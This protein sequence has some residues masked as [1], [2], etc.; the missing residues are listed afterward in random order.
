MASVAEVATV[1]PAEEQDTG[2][3]FYSLRAK[4]VCGAHE[5]APRAAALLACAPAAGVFAVATAS[6]VSVA[7]CCDLAA[8]GVDGA[9]LASLAGA[10][11]VEHAAAS[12]VTL[13]ADGTLLCVVTGREA[14]FYGVVALLGAAGAAGAP[15]PP[16]REILTLGVEAGDIV[17]AVFS[18]VAASRELLL[19]TASGQALM[20]SG[21]DGSEGVQTRA[22]R[23]GVGAAS[24]APGGD[25]VALGVGGQV[26]SVAVS[27]AGTGWAARLCDRAMEE[28]MAGLDGALRVEA[29]AW[30]TAGTVLATVTAVEGDGTAALVALRVEGNDVYAC[31]VEGGVGLLEDDLLSAEP[32]GALTHCAAVSAWGVAVV[33]DR[34]AYDEHLSLV[35]CGWG[36][37]EGRPSPCLLRIGEDR[38]LAR[39]EM[40]DGADDFVTGLAMDLTRVGEPIDDPRDAEVAPLPCAPMLLVL[41]AAGVLWAYAL[42]AADGDAPVPAGSVV[43]SAAKI[44]ELPPP[45]QAAAL[46]A[47]ESF[48]SAPQA[49]PPAGEADDMGLKAALGAALP[50]SDDD[51]LGGSDEEAESSG[52]AA[53]SR[54]PAAVPPAALH[55][56][57]PDS[58]DDGSTHAGG[59]TGGDDGSSDDSAVESPL[60]MAAPAPA[61]AAAAVSAP[62]FTFPAASSAPAPLF[63]GAA[64]S[65]APALGFGGAAAST[66]AFGAAASTP[67]FGVTAACAPAGPLFTGATA[68][69]SPTSGALPT[70]GAAPATEPDAKSASPAAFPPAK[71]A[72]PAFGAKDESKAAA[73]SSD[74]FP[75]STS[76]VPAFGKPQGMAKAGEPK[77]KAV[78]VASTFPPMMSA[79]PAF[80]GAGDKSKGKAAAKEEKA[81]GPAA[82]ESGG[83]GAAFLQANK[84]SAGETAAAVEKEI[85]NAANKGSAPPPLLGSGASP[86]STPKFGAAVAGTALPPAPEAGG[87]AFGTS[88]A[89]AP[90]AVPA[91]KPAPKPASKPAPKMRPSPPPPPPH[92]PPPP[93]FG[94]VSG[95]ESVED[96]FASEIAS[97]VEAADGV[98]GVVDAVRSGAPTAPFR[99]VAAHT[100]PERTRALGERVA[101]LRARCDGGA[102]PRLGALRERLV[103]LRAGL[104]EAE[105]VAAATGG[106]GSAAAY[107]ADERPLP[108]AAAAL[109]QRLAERYGLMLSRVGEVRADLE[110]RERAAEAAS[111]AGAPR[112]MARYAAYREPPPGQLYGTIETQRAIARGYARRFDAI[113]ARMASL[114]M[115]AAAASGVEGSP[116]PGGTPL[117]LLGAPS[118]VRG[119]GAAHWDS[120][121]AGK[122]SIRRRLAGRL[123]PDSTPRVT[124]AKKAP[125][126]PGS[127]SARGRGSR[128]LALNFD[129]TGSGSESVASMSISAERSQVSMSISSAAPRKRV[130]A[131]TTPVSGLGAFGGKRTPTPAT[132]AAEK[133]ENSAESPLSGPPSIKVAKV[134]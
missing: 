51:D 104:A 90:N 75:A 27:G 3:F 33:A 32:Q 115:A 6:G 20:A 96:A 63:G 16:P 64:A 14:Y 107:L 100:L 108:P 130:V 106:D 98:A 94:D 39:V 47:E 15:P 43:N 21:M 49:G 70:F 68:G 132:R 50:G 109:Q 113:E 84:K 88:P 61:A 56:G 11:A 85:E 119:G 42:G 82:A 111:A 1:A 62:P 13:S 10:A 34:R 31:D 87:F 66:P 89:D 77:R 110:G 36:Q 86:S 54:S 121:G 59:S 97:V 120:G 81:P 9:P 102:R 128:P 117:M 78:T 95:A 26:E 2:A 29:L 116:P 24:W 5:G 19:V 114:G 124:S 72:V 38:A 101:A 58:D 4:V 67:A 83:W 57:L 37:E 25:F 126:T 76:T 133:D 18:P 79:L 60:R 105:A 131:G 44:P 112:V 35:S 45:M 74:A 28:S 53:E 118:S 80:G 52:D 40:A 99:A 55:A 30:P 123:A 93:S 12:C 92:S 22:L 69:F 23:N 7:P 17:Q 129:A 127:A 71:G 73:S 41:T 122:S 65:S 46:A 103:D 48:P 8:A 125:A 134:R 91:P